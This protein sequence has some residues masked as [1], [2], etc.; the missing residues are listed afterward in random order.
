M[1]LRTDDC[2]TING[3]T[4]I[5]FWQVLSVLETKVGLSPHS[6]DFLLWISP[7]T[8]EP[9]QVVS[10]SLR[11]RPGFYHSALIQYFVSLSGADMC[12]LG[13]CCGGRLKC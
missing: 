13:V 8:Q 9:A 2:V 11:H 6:A 10:F 7:I 3:Q 4:A 5:W 12:G 1:L